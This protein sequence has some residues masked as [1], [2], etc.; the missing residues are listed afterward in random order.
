MYILQPE[1][2][3]VRRIKAKNISSELNSSHFS[4]VIALL[5]VKFKIYLPWSTALQLLLRQ[6]QPFC[7]KRNASL[8]KGAMFI[9]SKQL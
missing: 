3:L 8:L 1:A 2:I 5:T 7:V 6:Y 9:N 4:I